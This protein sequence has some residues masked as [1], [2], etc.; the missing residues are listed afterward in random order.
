VKPTPFAYF[1]PDTVEEAVACLSAHSGEARVL[2]GGQ[3][4]LAMMHQRLVRPTALVDLGRIGGLCF[5]SADSGV[6]RVGAMTRHVDIE[7]IRDAAVCAGY[8]VL[9]ETAGL[10]GHLPIRTRGTFGGSL[11]HADPRSEWCLLAVLLDAEIVV[12]GAAVERV[13]D[14]SSFFVGPYRTRLGPDEIVVEA[15]FRYPAP[16]AVLTEFAV[17][18]GGYPLVAAAAAVD[19]DPHGRIGAAR[20]ALGGVTGRP[21]RLP[22]V[23]MALLGERPDTALFD[24]A[25]RLAVEA[26]T[27]VAD[28]D[29][30][31]DR[32]YRLELAAALTT[33][34]V[35]ES[36]ARNGR[37]SPDGREVPDG[38]QTSDG[39]NEEKGGRP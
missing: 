18:H 17:Q 37:R 36:V 29:D 21:V 30:H 28:G 34:A 12:R 4:L 23:E 10:I 35:R 39:S 27:P 3:S 19:L 11:A 31:D 13:L 33:R 9:P 16:S 7:R 6:L 38:G 24:A 2:A 20:V 22:D 15:R 26:V 14:A 32:S 8:G 5:L 1:R 25:G